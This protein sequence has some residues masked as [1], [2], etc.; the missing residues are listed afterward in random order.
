MS[1]LDLGLAAPK[2]APFRYVHTED[3]RLEAAETYWGRPGE[4]QV[5][6][7]SKGA[8]VKWWFWFVLD[9]PGSTGCAAKSRE[10][11]LV[12]AAKLC[13]LTPAEADWRPREQLARSH[14]KRRD[15]WRAMRRLEREQELGGFAT[16]MRET[17][18][19]ERQLEHRPFRVGDRVQWAR[20]FLFYTGGM[21]LGG[22]ADRRWHRT[23]TII[24]LKDGF[25]R[26]CWRDRSKQWAAPQNL[27]RLDESWWRGEAGTLRGYG[28]ARTFAD[29][30]RRSKRGRTA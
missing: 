29:L 12:Q 15:I 16:A 18:I 27:A 28:G 13:R 7:H 2:P 26:I 10:D 21:T 9:G 14:E 17:A 19:R 3:A 6:C 22:L 1:Q 25:V 20:P 5:E 11:A 24:E 30:E 8:T 23:G 4:L